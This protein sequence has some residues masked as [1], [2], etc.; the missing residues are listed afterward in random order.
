MTCYST[1]VETCRYNC[2]F[3]IDGHCGRSAIEERYEE[4]ANKALSLPVHE[5]RSALAKVEM[6]R[7]EEYDTLYDL[8]IGRMVFV[9]RD[10]A[11]PF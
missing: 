2:L 10:E 4:R 8:A 9:V 11:L 7:N 1:R 5:V 6:A 3:H